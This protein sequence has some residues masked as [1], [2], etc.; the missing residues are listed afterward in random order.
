[1]PKQLLWKQLFRF[2]ELKEKEGDLSALAMAASAELGL[3]AKV[4]NAAAPAWVAG[5]IAGNASLSGW[6]KRLQVAQEYAAAG[7]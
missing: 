3:R 6:L 5:A 7:A 4:T 2:L 1:M